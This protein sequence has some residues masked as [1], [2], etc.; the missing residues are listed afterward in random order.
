[1]KV[2][3]QQCQSHLKLISTCSKIPQELLEQVSCRTQSLSVLRTMDQ[4]KETKR[5]QNIC[6]SIIAKLQG[7]GIA[8]SVVSSVVGD[9]EELASGL[10]SQVK[11]QVLS[12]VPKD[13]PVR[14]ALEKDLETFENPFIN[15]NT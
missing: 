4:V 7:S 14:A 11:Q 2:E 6:A 3:M 5:T 13:N 15:F 12:A 10:H 8:N 9:L 1:M